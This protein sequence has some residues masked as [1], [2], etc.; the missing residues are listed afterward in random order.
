MMRNGLPGFDDW[1]NHGPTGFTLFRF[2]IPHLMNFNGMAIYLD[3]DM[4]VLEPIEELATFFRPGHWCQHSDIQGDCVSVI[5]CAALRSIPSWPTI[6]ELKSG[7]LRKWDVRKL[8]APIISRTVPDEWNSMDKWHENI[9]LLHFTSLDTQPW[10]PV[11][12]Y[13]YKAHPDQK[14]ER[15]WHAWRLLYEAY[16]QP[17]AE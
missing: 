17:G 16:R 4:L 5:D 9:K 6:D 13:N 14:A 2:A 8:L 1:Q 7:S 12:G 15:L 11:P 3:C 10:H